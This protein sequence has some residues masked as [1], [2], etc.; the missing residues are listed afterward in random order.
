[1]TPEADTAAGR[2]ELSIRVQDVH[3]HYEVLARRNESFGDLATSGFRRRAMHR[4]RA[5]EGISFDLARGDALGVV[6]HNGAGKTTLLQVIAGLLRPSK[7]EVL[8]SNQP[9]LLGV[10]AALNPRI[11]GRLNVELGCRALGMETDEIATLTPEIIEFAG[12]SEFIDLPVNTYSTGMRARLGFAIST[13]SKPEILLI[14]EALAVGDKDFRERS[15]ARLRGL[16]K[17]AGVVV[18][19]S[20]GLGEIG[21][22]C[23]KVLWLHEGTMKMFGATDE[24]LAAYEAGALAVERK[25]SSSTDSEQISDQRL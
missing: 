1:M 5:L 17:A 21:N 20:H 18:L 22:S 9:Q 13:V 16:R 11:T 23:N 25:V 24:V 4:V 15:L 2:P 10:Q 8:V 19:V 6:G 7:G 3:V 12:L 14:D